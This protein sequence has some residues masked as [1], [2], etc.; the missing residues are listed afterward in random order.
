MGATLLLATKALS[1]GVSWPW[2]LAGVEGA[3]WVLLPGVTDPEMEWGCTPEHNAGTKEDITQSYDHVR[4][5]KRN[6]ENLF[7]FSAK[8]IHL[9][10]FVKYML[11]IIILNRNYHIL[12]HFF[13]SSSLHY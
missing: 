10:C 6:H 7:T 8:L 5:K 11:C 13:Q 12:I 1:W 4:M 9:K 2:I 3:K